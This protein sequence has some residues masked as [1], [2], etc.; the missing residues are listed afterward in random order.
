[1]AERIRSELEAKPFMTPSGIM[2][3]TVSAG[4]AVGSAELESLQALLDRADVALY[5]A[6]AAGRNRV[7]TSGHFWTVPGSAASANSG[8][9][10]PRLM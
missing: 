7:Q 2:K 1:M 4:I 3:A 5:Q 8:D 9:L 10:A 6:K